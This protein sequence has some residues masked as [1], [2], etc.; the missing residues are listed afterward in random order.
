MAALSV[1]FFV[2]SLGKLLHP[3]A[4]LR[5]VAGYQMLPAPVEGLVAASLPGVEMSVA[6]LLFL[7]LFVPAKRLRR[8]EPYVIAAAWT[9][10]GMLVVFIIVISV[11]LLRG[12]EMDCGC[13]DLIGNYIPFLASDRTTWGTVARDVVMLA[14]TLPALRG[15]R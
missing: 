14:M 6:I 3:K 2:S 10:A 11:N 5:A 13:F 7:G 1:I 9:A 4:F 8:V 15:R 12:I